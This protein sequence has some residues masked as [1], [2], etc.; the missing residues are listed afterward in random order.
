M[1]TRCISACNCVADVRQPGFL[2]APLRSHPTPRPLVAVRCIAL[3][4]LCSPAD[5]TPLRLCTTTLPPHLQPP[6]EWLVASRP[7]ATTAADAVRRGSSSPAGY[8]KRRG[9][10]QRP[11]V[12]PLSTAAWLSLSSGTGRV[13]VTVAAAATATHGTAASFECARLP[14]RCAATPCALRTT[15]SR[16]SYGA[17]GAVLRFAQRRAGVGRRL[18]IHGAAGVGDGGSKCSSGPVL[19]Y[20]AP[21]CCV[22]RWRTRCAVGRRAASP[23]AAGGGSVSPVGRVPTCEAGALRC[24]WTSPR[25]RRCSVAG[26]QGARRVPAALGDAVMTSGPIAVRLRRYPAATCDMRQPRRAFGSTAAHHR[27]P[28]A[29]SAAPLDCSLHCSRPA[30]SRRAT[31]AAR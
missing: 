9:T 30:S 17:G 24:R 15:G 2:A 19:L 27:P 11:P 20:D 22:Q 12:R 25:R 31:S 18:L 5:L 10:R 14:R 8:L 21:T 1:R 4:L 3:A 26:P 16:R 6:T 13:G 28:R 7:A 23:D 29:A